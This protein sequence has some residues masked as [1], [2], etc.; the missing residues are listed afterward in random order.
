M[1]VYISPLPTYTSILSFSRI[2]LCTSIQNCLDITGLTHT[3]TSS[4]NTHPITYTS[5]CVPSEVPCAIFNYLIMLTPRMYILFQYTA[6]APNRSCIGERNASA[7]R[8]MPTS[9]VNW[10]RL[11]DWDCI[12]QFILQY[13]HGLVQIQNVWRVQDE[14]A[15]DLV[16]DTICIDV[17]TTRHFSQYLLMCPHHTSRCVTF[18]KWWAAFR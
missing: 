7:W 3:H 4:S 10:H 8:I 2:E 14:P 16:Y 11:L 6:I 12:Q 9:V 17:V 15:W 13:I 18:C 5:L 1:R